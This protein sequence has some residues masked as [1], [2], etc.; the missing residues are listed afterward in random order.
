MACPSLPHPSWGDGSAAASVEAAVANGGTLFAAHEGAGATMEP[1]AL[2]GSAALVA[3]GEGEGGAGLPPT[4]IRVSPASSSGPSSSL[5]LA[6]SFDA[7]HSNHALSE[8]I[9]SSLGLTSAPIRIDSMCKYGLLSRGDAH[10]YLRFP[11]PGYSENVWDHAPGVVLLQEAGGVVT[12][13]S[14]K[15][16]DFSRGRALSDNYGV[17]ASNSREV[18]DKLI[19]AIA[20]ARATATTTTA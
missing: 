13:A 8:S 9:A 4:P 3:E 11:R 7:G 19:A 1:L 2:P 16:L 14:G 20:A 6:E 18:H 12:D 17:V 15:P 10:L 5:V